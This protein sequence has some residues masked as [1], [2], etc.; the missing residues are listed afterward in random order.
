MAGDRIAKVLIANRGEIAVRIIRACREMAIQ[1][2]AI[3]SDA[4]RLGLHVRMAD[5]AYSIGPPPA[6]ESYLC[7]DKIIDVAQNCGADAIHPG[8]GFLAENPE[9]AEKV[10]AAG[11]CFIGP[12]AAAMRLMGDKTAARAQMVAAGVPVVPGTQQALRD[13]R[14]ALTEARK[15]GLPVM[16]KAAAGGGG[17]GM[18][19]VRDEQELTAA[20][21]SATS[22]A[23]SAFGDGRVYIEKY[24][25]APRHIEF[26]ILADHQ[27]NVLHLGERECSIQRRHQKVVEEAPSTVLTE[28]T[29]HQMGQAAVQAAKACDYRNAGTIEFMLDQNGKFYFLEMNTRLQVEHP[30]TEMVTGLD[31]VKEQIRIASGEPLRFSQEDIRAHGHAIEC[32]IYAEDSHNNFLPST[33]TLT[34]LAPAAGPGVRDDNGYYTGAE[35]SIY[36]D[37]LIAKLITWGSDRSEAIARMQRALAEYVVV[38]VETSIPF[39]QAV[40]GHEKFLAGV[41]DTHFIEKEFSRNGVFD[42]D[43]TAPSAETDLEAAVLAVAAYHHQNKHRQAPAPSNRC[44]DRP[45]P[46]KNAGRLKG[47]RR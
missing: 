46:W 16:L 15:I 26:Q 22:E 35:V 19:I 2:V 34:T 20:F 44:E 17:K 13:D 25:E 3:F 47:L 10:T 6:L 21:R 11:L 4:D 5:E 7:Q 31:L 42:L 41:F 40:M 14:G 43:G 45:N 29:R 28:E 38:G 1:S 18:R 36:Y 32:R 33:G 23:E 37:P 30:V 9:F 27:G 24:I 12:T 39:C 8:Y